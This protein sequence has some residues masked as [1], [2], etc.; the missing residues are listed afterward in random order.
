MRNDKE[1]QGKKLGEVIKKAWNDEAFMQRLLEDATPV[2]IEH[3]VQ[4]P[5]GMQV[6]AVTN[7]DKLSHFVIPPKPS[8]MLSDEDLDGVAAG[9]SQQQASEIAQGIAAEQTYNRQV[10]NAIYGKCPGDLG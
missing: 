9:M 5:A 1:A 4:L 2:L 7:S 8:T 10:T 3:G 6:K